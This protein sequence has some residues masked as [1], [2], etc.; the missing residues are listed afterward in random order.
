[1]VFCFQLCGYTVAMLQ[2]CDR[3]LIVLMFLFLQMFEPGS[4]PASELGSEGREDDKKDTKHAP[5]LLEGPD[6]QE[7]GMYMSISTQPVV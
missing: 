6:I 3:E 4:S 2:I 1:M 7:D 5:D